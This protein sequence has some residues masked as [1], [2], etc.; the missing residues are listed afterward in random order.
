MK[1]IG[2]LTSPYVRKTRVVL[3]EK[4][5][6]F[7]FVA[8]DV[9]SADT[10]IQQSNPL[11]KV[12][13]LDMEDG[14]FLFDSAVIAEYLDTLTPVGKLLPANTGRERANVKCWEALASGVL[15]A[16]ILVRL[17]KNQRP[18]EQQS[19]VWIERQ[20]RK[21]HAGLNAMS[22]GLGEMP[23]C[24][25]NHFTLADI[26]VGCALGWL[27]FRFPEID[28]RGDYPNLAKLFDKL[29]ERPSFQET[30]PK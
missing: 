9:W 22:E 5:L 11:G 25:G 1:L 30:R 6:E 4:R 19:A 18:P 12:P 14:T 27:T 16:A 10:V 26:A 29:A 23:F 3:A 24:A 21:V 8:E 28:W 2:S 20:M 7:E 13:C 17:E 15:D